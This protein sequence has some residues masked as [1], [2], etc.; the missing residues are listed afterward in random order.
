MTKKIIIAVATLFTLG[1]ITSIPV[2]AV[3]ESYNW[4]FY[5]ANGYL[6][7]NSGYKND[8][9]QNYYLTIN[10][11]NISATNIFGT[12]IRRASDDATMSPYA[13]HN[14]YET[15]AKYWYTSTVNTSTLYY[16]RGKKDDSST[17]STQLNVSGR[18]TY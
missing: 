4:T 1:L 15:S 7:T 18:V 17:A 5:S 9:E 3:T 16:M 14:S 10:N 12:R 11:G 2:M 8:N 6:S 13:L